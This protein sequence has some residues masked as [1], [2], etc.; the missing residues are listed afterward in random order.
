VLTEVHRSCELILIA[1]DSQVSLCCVTS[2]LRE[3]LRM[4]TA[5]YLTQIPPSPIPEI[6]LRILRSY[7]QG[8]WTEVR[9]KTVIRHLNWRQTAGQ[10][11]SRLMGRTVENVCKITCMPNAGQ[12]YGSS[13]DI[14][15]ERTA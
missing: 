12:S 4:L 1:A 2:R 9:N 6:V 10:M 5:P 3:V 13:E 8:N 14:I 7:L 11:K 15:D